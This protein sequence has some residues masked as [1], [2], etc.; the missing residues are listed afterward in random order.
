M[1]EVLLNGESRS[2]DSGLTLA[3]LLDIIGVHGETV[4][5]ERNGKLVSRAQFDREPV[6]DGDRLE[7]I[8][9][10]GGG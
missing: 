9:I 3:R 2:V 6:A 7:L 5:V 10:V 1:I 4:V 8:R